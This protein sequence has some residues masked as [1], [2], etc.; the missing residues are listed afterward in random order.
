MSHPRHIAIIM[1]GNGRWAK[2][3]MIPRTVGHV[4][5]AATVRKVVQACVRAGVSHLSVFAFSTENWRRPPEEVRKLMDLIVQYLQKELRD[6]QE[7]GIRLRVIGDRASLGPELCG[8]IERVEQVTQN[9]DR[10]HL[11]VAVN[12]GGQ[13]DILQAMR[14]WQAERPDQCLDDL[15][16]A[17]LSAYLS[18]ADLPDPDL[19]IRTGGEARVSNFMLWQMAYTEMFFTDVLWPDFSEAHLQK[20]LHWYGQRVRRFGRTDEQVAAEMPAMAQRK[21]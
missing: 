13:W 7:S 4:K 12:Y 15:G 11:T 20:A 17:D 6:L 19:L 9:N 21:A 14:R 2:K 16:P 5:G 3:R 8:W 18:T 10:F 1:D